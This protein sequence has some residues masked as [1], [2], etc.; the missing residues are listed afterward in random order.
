MNRYT[1]EEF[2]RLA[3]ER[4]PR[5]SKQDAITRM[6]KDYAVV[7]MNRQNSKKKAYM[8]RENF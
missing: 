2:E 3:K 5:L 6:R 1:K 7:V 8:I 4:Y